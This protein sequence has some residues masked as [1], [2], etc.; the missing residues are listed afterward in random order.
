MLVLVANNGHDSLLSPTAI[1]ARFMLLTDV[2]LP[3]IGGRQLAEA[4][5]R[6]RPEMKVMYVSGYSEHAALG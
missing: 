3:K 1:V 2:V 5:S 6:R 4:V